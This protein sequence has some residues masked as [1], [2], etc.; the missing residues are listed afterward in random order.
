[1]QIQI[2]ERNVE[3]PEGLRAHVERRLG[4]ALGRLGERISRVIVRF[5]DTNGHRGGADKR[6]QIDVHLRPSGNVRV[7]DTDADIYAASDRAADHASRAVARLL[8]RQREWDELP[9]R[10]R[11]GGES[12]S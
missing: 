12:R 2:R 4:F 8:H 5:S 6:C 11:T 1:M 7:G 9:I 3:L 10:S